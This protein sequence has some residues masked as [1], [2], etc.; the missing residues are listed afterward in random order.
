MGSMES[1]PSDPAEGSTKPSIHRPSSLWTLDE[2]ALEASVCR[3]FLELEIERGRLVAVRLSN[4]I[5]VRNSD[6]EKYLN[7][8]ATAGAAAH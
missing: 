1:K 7:A 4:R 2:L 5:R 6:W 3:R 8:G